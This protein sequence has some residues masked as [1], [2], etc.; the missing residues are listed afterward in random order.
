MAAHPVI[1]VLDQFR[2]HQV[3]KECA[4]ERVRCNLPVILNAYE[5][6]CKSCIVEVQLW[7]FDQSLVDIRVKR[8][9]T[10][11]D[12]RGLKKRYPLTD[13]LVTDSCVIGETGKVEQLPDSTGAQSQ[14]AL[15]LS[16]LLDVGEL[17]QVAKKARSA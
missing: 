15:K 13:G 6:T 7:R 12:E 3:L 17:S 16:E 9:Q 2:N 5:P 4:P 11:Q 10:K 1:S 8:R 14:E